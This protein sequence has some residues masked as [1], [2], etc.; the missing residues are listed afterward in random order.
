[1]VYVG[2]RIPEVEAELAQRWDSKSEAVREVEQQELYDYQETHD[3]SRA[4]QGA[5]LPQ[6]WLVRQGS[7]YSITSDS[8][9]V[10]ESVE[11]V[12]RTLTAVV[13][14]LLGRVLSA[15]D[16]RSKALLDVWKNRLVVPDDLTL[17]I[18]TRLDSEMRALIEE[19]RPPVEYWELDG[20]RYILNE[21]TA[22]ARMMSVLPAEDIRQVVT[23]LRASP[24][25][26]VDDL[27]SLSEAV[28]AELVPGR[29]Y[30]Q[31]YFA[32]V[33]LREHFGLDTEDRADPDAFCQRWGIPVETLALAA[34][35]VDAI[36]CWG[37]RH[38]PA[39]FVNSRGKHNLSA[40]GKRATIAHEIAHLLLDRSGALPLAEVAGG[41]SPAVVEERARAF[42]AEFL[43]PRE[44][45]GREFATTSDPSKALG[46]LKRRFGVSGEIVAW[47]A[48][49]SSIAL[50]NAARTFLR[51]QVSQ[52]SR[53]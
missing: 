20:D 10:V 17:E 6:V 29:P 42:G 49:N 39:V 15:G 21:L 52:P 16:E 28:S 1:M 36:A 50:S 33:W 4:L 53:F 27:D 30:D 38:G 25:H 47:Q 46:R 5:V 23:A 7:Q 51:F 40:A 45:A 43:I 18:A 44:V 41:L 8:V 31:G 12:L 34:T 13:E 22:A 32:A 11:E 9:A 2:G 26:E 19:G 14:M 37:P 3:L 24:A 35:T 48:R